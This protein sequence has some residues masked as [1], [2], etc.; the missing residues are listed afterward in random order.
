LTKRLKYYPGF[1]AI[2]IILWSCSSSEP[3][4]KRSAEGV[5]NQAKALFDDEEYFDAKNKFDIITL[6]YPASQYADDAQFYIGECHYKREEFVLA[7]YHFSL[8]RRIY[9]N[10]PYFK[11]S[12][13]KTALCYYMLSPAYDRDQDYTLKAV[14]ALSEFQSVYPNDS[15]SVIAENYFNELRSKLAHRDYSIAEIYRKLWS[16]NSSLIYYDK[17]IDNFDDTKYYEPA[18]VGKIEVLVEM[19][20]Y[21]QAI[22][23]IELYFSIFK[24]GAHTENVRT[25]RSSIPISEEN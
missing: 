3:L 19:K 20:K 23:A 18:F 10:S 16:P 7:S 22:S 24:Q 2:V 15:L 12:M 4:E 8:L 9:P 14:Q 1:I 13:F 11:E 21:D 17:V 5:F 25:L 6:Q